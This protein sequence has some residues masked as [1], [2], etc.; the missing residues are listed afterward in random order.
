L[1]G[2]VRAPPAVFFGRHFWRDRNAGNYRS[3]RKLTDPENYFYF[4]FRAGVGPRTAEK[5]YPLGLTPN[6]H[7]FNKL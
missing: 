7:H 5:N 2:G 6:L 1:A 4:F 3:A